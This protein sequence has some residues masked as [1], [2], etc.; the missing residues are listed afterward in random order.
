MLSSGTIAPTS[1]PTIF[2]M[3]PKRGDITDVNKWRP[4]PVFKITYK[5]FAK[6]VHNRKHLLDAAQ[7]LDQFGFRP[8]M[9]ME[10]VLI[11][12]ET[13][14]EKSLAWELDL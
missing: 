2:K 8:L 10:H 14:P 5:V 1:Q 9:E 4:I 13:V 12:I 7:P 3:L 6:M 11:I